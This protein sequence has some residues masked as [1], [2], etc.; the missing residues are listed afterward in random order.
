[1]AAA[2]GGGGAVG[3][4]LILLRL[5][6]PWGWRSSKG[7]PVLSKVRVCSKVRAKVVSNFK[8]TK[9]SRAVPMVITIRG[10]ITISLSAKLFGSNRLI[11]KVNLLLPLL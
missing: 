10:I 7:H 5:R 9:V 8:P 6:L 4:L 2:G 1:M 3:E 11:S